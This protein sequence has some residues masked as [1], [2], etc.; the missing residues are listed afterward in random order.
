M[1]NVWDS[2]TAKKHAVAE[3]SLLHATY[4]GGM[5]KSLVMDKDRDNGAIVGR[6]AVASDYKDM[7]AFDAKPAVAGE[8]VYLVLSVPFG[9]NTDRKYMTEECWFF[10][11]KGEVAR[12]YELRAKDLRL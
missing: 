1:A 12:C 10:N 5:I 11:Q 9:Y 2:L 4:A 8:P 3:S 6:S 7:Q